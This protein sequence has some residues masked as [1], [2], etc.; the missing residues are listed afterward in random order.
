MKLYRPVGITELELIATAQF[1]AFPHRLVHQP[2]FYPVLN[3]PYAEAIAR[4]WNTKDPNSGFAGFVTEFDIDDTFVLRYHVQ[5]V[6]SRDDQELWVPAEELTE[7]NRHI[8]H[9]IRIAASYYG[10]LHKI[11][12]DPAT[13]LPT[14][15]A[16]ALALLIT[17]H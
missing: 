14:A 12:I 6:G 16:S 5:I 3:F 2:I 1:R 13:K 4:N 10:E 15:V 11:E 8:Q 7:F 9:P 17:T